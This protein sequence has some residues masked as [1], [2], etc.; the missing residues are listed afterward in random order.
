MLRREAFHKKEKI[1]C[2]T[3]QQEKEMF[4]SVI[5]FPRS[6]NDVTELGRMGLQAEAEQ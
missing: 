5:E 3:K 4:R 1:T 2:G 6:R